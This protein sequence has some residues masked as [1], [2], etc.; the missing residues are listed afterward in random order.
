MAGS[1]P[2]PPAPVTARPGGCTIRV[3]VVPR[4]GRTAVDG[5]REGALLIRLAAAPVDGEANEALVAFLAR[6]LGVPRRAVRLV[7]G[8]RARDKRLE[9]DGVAAEAASAALAGRS[10]TA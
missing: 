5:E 10:R 4:S 3:R 7:A 9:V 6:Q 1:A 2:V 8:D